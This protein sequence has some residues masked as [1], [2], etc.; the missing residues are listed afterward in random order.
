MTATLIIVSV[1]GTTFNPSNF[2]SVA[3]WVDAQ[4]AST[5]TTNGTNVVSVQDKSPH[6]FAFSSMPGH[7]PTTVTSNGINGL[8]SIRFNWKGL[9][10]STLVY[11]DLTGFDWMEG[12]EGSGVDVFIVLKT[13]QSDPSDGIN[14][15]LG[16][17]GKQEA[18]L[19]PHGTI[20]HHWFVGLHTRRTRIRL[21]EG[22]FSWPMGAPYFGSSTYSVDDQIVGDTVYLLHWRLDGT[23]HTHE[24]NGVSVDLCQGASCSGNQAGFESKSLDDV[25]KRTNITIASNLEGP[26]DNPDSNAKFWAGDIGEIVVFEN[27]LSEGDAQLVTD[28]LGHK[29]AI[30]E[31]PEPTSIILIWAG[32]IGMLAY[33]GAREQ[34]HR[35]QNHR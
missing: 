2:G 32:L 11:E 28:A 35:T 27:G 22:P 5:V 7:T 33:R 23:S 29:W 1:I 21:L 13:P 31:I 26:I 9:N 24:V 20:K 15:F 8:P 16:S 19:P 12:P 18:E 30:V 17:H 34:C 3:L 4:D 10:S 6:A 14:A 25:T